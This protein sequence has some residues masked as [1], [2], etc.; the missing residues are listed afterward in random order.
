MDAPPALTKARKIMDTIAVTQEP[1]T[2]AE[3]GGARATQPFKPA[4]T[5][6]RTPQRTGTTTLDD[7]ASGDS[8]D[9]DSLCHSPTVATTLDL[10]HKKAIEMLRKIR[11]KGDNLAIRNA[12]IAML[13][14]SIETKQ[15]TFPTMSQQDTKEDHRISSIENNVKEIKKT[16]KDMQAMLAASNPKT[17]AQVAASPSN[18]RITD[19]QAQIETAKRERLEQA[20]KERAKTEVTL[21]FRNASE[22]MLTFMENTNE[23]DYATKLQTAI[24]EDAT[25]ANIT[26]CK[27]RKLPGKILKIQCE[28][29]NNATQLRELNWEQALQGASTVKPMYGVVLHGVSKQVIDAT[30]TPQSEMKETIQSA[31]T[32]NV[33]QVTPLTKKSRNPDAPTQSIVVFTSCPKKQ[34]TQSWMGSASR[35]DITQPKDTTHNVKSNNVS[36]AKD[37]DTKPKAVPGK[38]RVGAALRSTRQRHA[39]RRSTNARI[40]VAHILPGTM[41]ARDDLK[42]MRS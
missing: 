38:Q 31:N 6:P 16:M 2:S 12:V 1:L 27:V 7:S 42:N 41:N 3:Q 29:E 34:T 26:I 22:T 23:S 14:E 21:T 10:M 9:E 19:T 25:M 32:I 28:N 18:P 20:R 40:A 11:T 30:I 36:N 5:L 4:N 8:S 39:P 24:R 15:Q 35:V 37:T 17:W 13:K 33:L